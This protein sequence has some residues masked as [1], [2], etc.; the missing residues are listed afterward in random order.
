M[1]RLEAKE[2]FRIGQMRGI[3][4]SILCEKYSVNRVDKHFTGYKVFI[5]KEIPSLSARIQYVYA[6]FEKYKNG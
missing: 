2:K 1:N 4:K 5:N 3:Y 6:L